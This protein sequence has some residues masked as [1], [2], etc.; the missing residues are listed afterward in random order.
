MKSHC[1][2]REWQYQEEGPER[3]RKLPHMY[4]QI[5]DTNNNVLQTLQTISNDDTRGVWQ[6]AG[7]SLDAYK[8]QTIRVRFRVTNNVS[9]PTGFYVD[10]V[11]LDTLNAYSP[12]CVYLPVILKN[13]P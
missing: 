8:G 1:L 3:I 9:N 12:S 7:F 5:L 6:S 4:V 11:T 10:D 2:V 13:A